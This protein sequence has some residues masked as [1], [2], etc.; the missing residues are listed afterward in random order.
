MGFLSKFFEKR[1]QVKHKRDD[2][3][4]GIISEFRQNVE[5]IETLLKNELHY[6]DPEVSQRYIDRYESIATNTKQKDKV[7]RKSSMYGELV[8]QSKVSGQFMSMFRETIPLHNENSLKKLIEIN[9]KLFFVEGKEFDRQQK[10]CIV[11]DV[12]NH[13][14]IS[15]AGTGK[16]MTIVGKVKYLIKT[17]KCDYRKI[18]V[19]SFTNKTAA[20][21]RG[22]IRNET[23]YEVE[24]CTFHKMGL[25]ILREASNHSVKVSDGKQFDFIMDALSE[26]SKEE[27]YCVKLLHYESELLERSNRAYWAERKLSK[28]EIGKLRTII[29]KKAETV[30]SYGERDIANFLYANNINYVYEVRYKVDEND[31]KYRPDFYL[32]DYRVYIEYYG[33]DRNGKVPTY[34]SSKDGKTPSETYVESM[35]WKRNLHMEKGTKLV[36]VFAYERWEGTLLC[37]LRDGLEGMGVVFPKNPVSIIEKDTMMS[38]SRL[39][40]SLLN[41]M[42]SRGLSLNDVWTMISNDKNNADDNVLIFSLFEPVFEKYQ[43]ELMESG[44]VDFNDMINLATKHIRE[45]NFIHDYDQVLIDEY[46]DISSSRINLLMEMRRAKD[47]NVFCVGDDWQSIYGFTGSNLDCLYGFQKYWGIAE[48][49]KVETTYRFPSKLIDISSKFILENP[50]QIHK[51]L[52]AHNDDGFNILEIRGLTEEKA[53]KEILDKV[54]KLP[55]KSTVFFLGRYN[56]DRNILFRDVRIEHQGS[57]IMIRGRYD[58]DAQ[59]QTV[60]GAK[61]LQADCIVLLNNRDEILGF[62]SKVID[63]PIVNLLNGWDESF[64]FSEERRAYY[65]ALTRT[66]KLLILLTVDGKVSSFVKEIEERNQGQMERN[67]FGECPVCGGRLVKVF[68]KYSYF[69]GCSNFSSKNC[70]YR[71]KMKEKIDQQ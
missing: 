39:F 2:L 1:Q 13:I 11:K 15:G 36:E 50:K 18:L 55:E 25:D 71:E 70:R 63:P 24:V 51:E 38:I 35:A 3:C 31:T 10:E 58:I 16:T 56:N 68:G 33:I 57:K 62:P 5:E 52:R 22:R 42:K 46:Q 17:G 23:G 4:S 19:L 69:L 8:V 20:E 34:F 27:T 7:L 37:N 14:V 28:E 54:V 49:S 47:F 12:H 26:L 53:L 9:S 64:P 45:G 65:V 41:R 67:Y 30:R 29:T 60:H 43:K 59:Y 48:E 21:L 61:G 40:E 44:K 66:K 32:P 6:L